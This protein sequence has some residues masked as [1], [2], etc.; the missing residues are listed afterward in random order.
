MTE[1][2][3]FTGNLTASNFPVTKSQLFP[4]KVP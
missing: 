4:G 2:S 1:N 3:P